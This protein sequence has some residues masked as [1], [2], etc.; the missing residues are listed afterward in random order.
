MARIMRCTDNHFFVAS[1][2]KLMFGSL[3]LGPFKKMQCPVDG[4]IVT[5]GYVKAENLTREQLEEAQKYRA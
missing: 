2:G 3:H 4:K 1:E 5:V